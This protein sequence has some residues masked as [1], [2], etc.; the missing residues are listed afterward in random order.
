VSAIDGIPLAEA[1]R[2]AAAAISDGSWAGI[3]GG[4]VAT[5]GAL[6]DLASDPIGGILGAGFGFVLEHVPMLSQ[7]L[8]L[9]SG[10]GEAIDSVVS[11]W[12]AE[13]A[14]PLA[15]TAAA[16][17]GALDRLRDGWEGIAADDYLYF[18]GLLADRQQALATAARA[19]G[20]GVRIAGTLVLSVREFIRDELSRFLGWMAAGYVIAAA[21][22]APTMGS[23]MITWM[24]SA[25]LRGAQLA[26]RFTGAIAELTDKLT[27]FTRGLGRLG[28][29]VEM[30]H[31]GTV[32]LRDGSRAL[33]VAAVRG[34]GG[35]ALGSLL[36]GRWVAAAPS[37]TGLPAEFGKSLGGA[38]VKSIG[39]GWRTFSAADADPS[40]DRAG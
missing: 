26:Q 39:D 24:N 15:D 21:A 13:V 17:A 11:A 5:V 40:D 2:D 28:D 14:A 25:V 4:A 31:R 29:A 35:S 1:V 7:A 16:S 32:G 30:L 20:A 23:S 34:R 8:D 9:V 19:A 36:T 27:A 33:R 3:G 18:A 6:G 10:D 12:T 37:L 22:A 38:A